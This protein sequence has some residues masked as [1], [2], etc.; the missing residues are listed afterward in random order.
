MKIR[1][2]LSL[3]IAALLF[4]S[5]AI[6]AVT[7]F[8]STGSALYSIFQT[9]TER[10]MTALKTIVNQREAGARAAARWFESSERIVE[11]IEKRDHDRLVDVGRLA[12]SSF[13]VDYFVVTDAQGTI[14][15]DARQP[16]RRGD[17]I[18]DQL[19]VTAAL[20]GQDEVSIEG[21]ARV[22]YSIR[23]GSPV[24]GANG[25]IIGVVSLGYTLSSEGFVDEVKNLLDC[26]V[27]IFDGATR[28][29][30]TIVQNGRQIVG[31]KLTDPRVQSTVL[32]E[33]SDYYGRSRIEGSAYVVAYSPLTTGDSGHPSGM[34]FVGTRMTR[35]QAIVR[36]I[37][38]GMLLALV[39]ILG[40]VLAAISLSMRNRFLPLETMAR[41]LVNNEND[42]TLRFSA[43]SHDEVGMVGMMLNDYFGEMA[44]LITN[45]KKHGSTTNQIGHKLS[46]SAE[47]VGTVVDRIGATLKTIHAR[48][49]G[50]GAELETVKQSVFEIDSKIAT[51]A[52]Q[53]NSQEVAIHQSS[54]A[55]EELV[56][57]IRS[58]NQTVQEKVN[59]SE[60][61]VKT[62]D[63]G[64]DDMQTTVQSINAIETSVHSIFDFVEIIQHLA[65]QTDL[66]AMNAAIEAAHAGH[67][68]HGFAVVADEMRKLSEE[69]GNSALRIKSAIAEIEQ[70]VS[71]AG[72]VATTANGTIERL[73]AGVGDLG[74]AMREI[75]RG[76]AE[77][78]SG[79]DQIVEALAELVGVANEI[80]GA[81]ASM[82]EKSL[83]IKRGVQSIAEDSDENSRAT[84]EIVESL[85]EI[86][87]AMSALRYH[88]SENLESVENLEREMAKF[89]I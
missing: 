33:G 44:N 77:M 13:G 38:G 32:A 11:G 54:S 67:Y 53:I 80:N 16:N 64:R 55:I 81:A 22:G 15:A 10:K 26:D 61:L 35:I 65:S 68:G 52:G 36:N 76:T 29:A 17:N 86:L 62:G 70:V 74:N 2:R 83:H 42:L 41:L 47:N 21:D 31:T 89:K 12:T 25:R 48:I 3:W 4:S 20:Q 46:E 19:N 27:T 50:A 88:G 7:I 78:S 49:A 85:P 59:I 63:A 5:F 84:H 69:T 87:A 14:L 71:K 24:R 57:T 6:L 1:T 79:S 30:T 28:I 45:L 60:A 66:L 58:I 72:D 23:A 82:K 40:T 73:T 39:V 9:D 51:T 75:G 56:G 18:G 43:D 37:F 34:L 8:L